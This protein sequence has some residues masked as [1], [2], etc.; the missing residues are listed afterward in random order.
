MYTDIKKVRE[1]NG[2]QFIDDFKKT[3][4][5]ITVPYCTGCS[6]ELRKNDVWEMAKENSIDYIMDYCPYA[7]KRICMTIK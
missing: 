5:F 1:I 3:R 2:Q 4:S 6:F 7:V